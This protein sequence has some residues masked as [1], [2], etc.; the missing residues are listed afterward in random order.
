M[1]ATPLITSATI[2]LHV[3]SPDFEPYESDM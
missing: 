1:S 3:P 2:P